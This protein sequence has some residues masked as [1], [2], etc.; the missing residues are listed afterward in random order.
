M[1]KLSPRKRK[2]YKNDTEYLRS[3]AS[4]TETQLKKEQ[5]LLKKG[6]IEIAKNM[7][8]LGLDNNIIYKVTKLSIEQI[9]ALR[10]E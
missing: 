5:D 4:W 10:K 2:A 8:E 6:A 7:I 3:E 9:E 1:A